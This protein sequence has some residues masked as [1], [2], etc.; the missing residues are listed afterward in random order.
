MPRRRPPLE[1][2]RL[3]LPIP[4][5]T[6]GEMRRRLGQ[7]RPGEQ[8]QIRWVT[9]Y[10]STGWASYD[11]TQITRLFEAAAEAGMR[12]DEG[13]VWKLMRRV[14][15]P[16]TRPLEVEEDGERWCVLLETG[17]RIRFRSQN[18]L[19]R[20]LNV[21]P[22]H[23]KETIRKLRVLGMI[24]VSGKGWLEFDARLG[25]KGAMLLRDRYIAFQRENIP[26]LAPIE[27]LDQSDVD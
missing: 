3:R 13:L 1:T 18:E 6:S 7:L 22:A 10:R 5:L 23:L 15:W 11:N 12:L 20:D 8:P 2:P 4:S 9:R 27:F 17:C 26:S 16:E 24:V 14:S 25:W 19:A 21:S